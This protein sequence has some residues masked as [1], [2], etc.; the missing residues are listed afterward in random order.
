MVYLQSRLVVTWLVPHETAA[1]SACSAYTIQPCTMSCHFMQSY[2]RRVAEHLEEWPGSFTYWGVMDTEI[3]A[4]KVDP[5]EENSPTAP[6]GLE[7]KTFQSRVQCSNHWAILAPQVNLLQTGG[8]NA[9]VILTGSAW[10]FFF[11]INF[12]CWLL[13]RYSFHP[14]VT[15]IA[16]KRSRPFCQKCRQQVTA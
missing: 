6:A 7:R 13:F 10:I 2:I 9:D 5:G 11:R 12:L 1:V 8:I 15:T 14:C 16:C 3:R 4:Q